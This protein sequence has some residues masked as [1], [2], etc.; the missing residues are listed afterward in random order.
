MS[1]HRFKVGQKVTLALGKGAGP[2]TGDY[3]VVQRLPSEG[4]GPQYRVKSEKETFMRMALE[5]TLSPR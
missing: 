3:T 2:A 1:K 5:R 4:S